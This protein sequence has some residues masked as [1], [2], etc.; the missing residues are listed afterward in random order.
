MN[1]IW[2]YTIQLGFNMWRDETSVP[3]VDA[4]FQCQSSGHYQH[5]M[6]T[7]RE[8]WRHVV[9]KLPSFG[10]NMLVIDLGEGVQ[11]KSHPELAVE[12]A[13]T[14]EELRAEL[15]H[16]REIGLEPIPMLNFSSYHDAWLQV[17]SHQKGSKVYNRTVADLIDEVCEIFDYPRFFHL[18]LNEEHLLNP[19]CP[20]LWWQHDYKREGLAPRAP[21]EWW[22]DLHH[23]I[24][25]VEKNG[26]RPW[27]YGD[28]YY[29]HP[30][31]WEENVPK[32]CVIS[33]GWFER[34][35]LGADGTYPQRRT[36]EAYR[37]TF[38]MEYDQIPVSS[39]WTCQQNT[40]QQVFQYME[41][42]YVNEHLL[43][44]NVCPM[45]ATVD[46]NYYSLLNNAHRLC[47]SREMFEESYPEN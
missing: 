14:V 30:E 12:G 3:E 1:R 35:L 36:Y 16:V 33:H 41:C 39:D 26:A 40:S 28:Y 4:E 31:R 43:G 32:S 20:R 25:C 5:T 8:T 45:Q 18:G 2:S 11:Y 42:G 34:I 24:A 15:T 38:E 17:Y 13:W 47:L 29:D 23:Y 27:I 9:D 7:D 19:A 44:F 6:L 37:D 22:R 10:I 46:I 21:E